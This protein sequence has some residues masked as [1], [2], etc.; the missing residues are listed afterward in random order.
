M[1]EKNNFYDK[2]SEFAKTKKLFE[3]ATPDIRYPLTFA[4]WK[5]LPD[6]L[7]PSA[8]FVTFYKPIIAV[9]LKMDN[10]RLSEQDKITSI[11]H[12]FIKV[13]KYIENNPNMYKPSIICEWVKQA[14]TEYDRCRSEAKKTGIAKIISNIQ[15]CEK[16]NEEIEADIYETIPCNDDSDLLITKALSETRAILLKLSTSQ[17][18]DLLKALSILLSDGEKKVPTNFRRKYPM[19]LAKLRKLLAEPASYY[20]DIHIDCDTFQDVINNEDIIASATVIL[21]DGTEAVYYGEKDITG[22]NAIKY[23]FIS[24]KGVHHV[25]FTKVLN[26]KVID[27]EPKN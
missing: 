26:L 9:A 11:M 4:E 20:Y 22:N 18:K 14:F 21:S 15:I 12:R 27:V 13:I 2:N 19:I 16:R 1:K 17:D 8:L 25:C 6:N 24:K 23:K 3:E 10:I 5:N 7:K